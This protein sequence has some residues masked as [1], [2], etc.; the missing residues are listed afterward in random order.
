MKKKDRG[1]ECESVNA[2]YQ[3]TVGEGDGSWRCFSSM[4]FKERLKEIPETEPRC[5][6][7]WCGGCAP[8]HPEIVKIPFPSGIGLTK[9]IA[10]P[11]KIT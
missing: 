7:R 3:L 11:M 10:R 4:L 8:A 5:G 9:R 2:F 6:S 1:C